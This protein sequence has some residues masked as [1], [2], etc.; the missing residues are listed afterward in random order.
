MKKHKV[1]KYFYVVI[2]ILFIIAICS[3]RHIKIDGNSMMPNYTNNEKIWVKKKFLN[4]NYNRFD[5]IIAKNPLAQNEEIIK[6]VMALPN[7][8]IYAK[9]GIIYVNGKRLK[10]PMKI[11]GETK[12]FGSF[13]L[14]DDE[15]F[16]LGDNRDNSTDSRNY[17]PIK[18][19][20]IHAK[21]Y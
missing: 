20:Q 10:E 1:M 19:K 12:N 14:T 17:G 11:C 4:E 21:K 8:T 13:K 18:I 2:G 9:N 3:I 15:Y 5:I 16:L 7:E 6:R